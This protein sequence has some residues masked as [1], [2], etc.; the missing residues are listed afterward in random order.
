MASESITAALKAHPEIRF[1]S[2]AAAD[3]YGNDTDEK[4][5]VRIHCSSHRG[6]NL[7]VGVSKQD[8]P[9]AIRAVYGVFA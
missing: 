2:L 9:R 8:L 5:P 1:V 4:I 3:I 7:V 6:M